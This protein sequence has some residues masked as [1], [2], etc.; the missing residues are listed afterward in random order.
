MGKLTDSIALVTG[1]SSGIGLAT[2]RVFTEEGATVF[3]TGRRQAAL[4]LAVAE[5]GES[6]IGIPSDI[7]SLEDIDR[8]C[9]II[10][11]R[12]GRLDILFANA[13]VGEFMPLQVATEEHFDKTFAV[14]VKGTF[15]TVQKALQ[16]M[17][18]GS[19]IILNASIAASKG[20]PSFS[21]YA[22][23]KAAVRAC[24]RGWIV[25]LRDRS[26]RVNVVSPGTIPTPGYDTLGLS[27]EEME[28]FISSQS[29]TNPS[30]RVGTP[31]EIAKAVL[32]LASDDSSYVNGIELFVDGGIAQI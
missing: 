5:L 22:A 29:E 17:P 18:D 4:D 10:N 23:S 7:A 28:A 8:V 27:V 15:F 2:A 3:I 20:F 19:S 21:V 32:F 25:E 11:D 30:G 6:V 12:Y 26:I 1:G 16:L 9:H 24:A 13:G 31:N 14:N